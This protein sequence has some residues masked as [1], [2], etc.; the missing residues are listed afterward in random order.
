MY[1]PKDV[2]DKSK[3]EVDLRS[4]EM[5]LLGQVTHDEMLSH[6]NWKESKMIKEVND[7]REG[8]EV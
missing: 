2:K 7:A 6:P 4:H 3:G 8:N 1:E 5:F